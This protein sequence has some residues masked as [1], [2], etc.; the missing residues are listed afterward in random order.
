[1]LIFCGFGLGIFLNEKLKFL[2]NVKI[3]AGWGEW[4]GGEWRVV[5]FISEN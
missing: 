3:W 1:M 4:R 5:F 2:M